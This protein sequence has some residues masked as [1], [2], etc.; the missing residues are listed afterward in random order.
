MVGTLSRHHRKTY[1]G[2]LEGR[3]AIG[4]CCS[5]HC[6]CYHVRGPKRKINRCGTCRMLVPQCR[7]PSHQALYEFVWASLHSLGYRQLE[8]ST[9]RLLLDP[10][11]R[12]RDEPRLRA[13]SELEHDAHKVGIGCVVWPTIWRG[14][15]AI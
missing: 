5:V 15:P 8:S 14:N 2:I 6:C 12:I 1:R 3:N 4:K 9:R 13:K 7:R 11:M 10:N